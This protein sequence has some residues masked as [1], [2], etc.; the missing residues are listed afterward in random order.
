M[1]SQTENTDNFAAKSIIA[2]DDQDYTLAAQPEM[3]KRKSQA[4]QQLLLDPK[5]L[6]QIDK[7]FTVSR[8]IYIQST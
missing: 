6:E 2:F 8:I 5:L 7:T 3:A 1:M 4:H